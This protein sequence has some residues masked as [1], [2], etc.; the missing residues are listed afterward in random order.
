[1]ELRIRGENVQAFAEAIVYEETVATQIIE[2]VCQIPMSA[3]ALGVRVENGQPHP[4]DAA[5]LAK[6]R[7]FVKIR[8]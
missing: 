4:E 7:L 8:L 1:V 5:R 3:R 2:Y 6:E